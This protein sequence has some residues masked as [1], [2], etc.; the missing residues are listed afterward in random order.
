[1]IQVDPPQAYGIVQYAQTVAML[2]RHGWPRTALFPHGGN[3]IVAGDRGR[4]RAWRRGVLSGRVRGFRRLLP[5]TPRSR[6][7]T[8]AVGASGH[9][10][11]GQAALYRIMQELS[12]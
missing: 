9:R 5:T 8:C 3:Q 12:A 7:V 2:E 11:R 1:V 10:L 4:L 6:R